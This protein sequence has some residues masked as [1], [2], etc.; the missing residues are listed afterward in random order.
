MINRNEKGGGEVDRLIG[1]LNKPPSFNEY[2]TRVKKL[3]AENVSLM[4]DQ[5]EV[6]RALK[7]TSTSLAAANAIIST[8]TTALLRHVPQSEVDKLFNGPGHAA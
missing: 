4:R 3:E 6:I 7:D 5:V 1:M 8:L 2:K